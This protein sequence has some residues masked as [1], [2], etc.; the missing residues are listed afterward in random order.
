MA[1]DLTRYKD[2]EAGKLTSENVNDLEASMKMLV[3]RI[4]DH[5]LFPNELARKGFCGHSGAVGHKSTTPYQSDVYVAKLKEIR[6][7]ACIPDEIVLL[8]DA[9]LLEFDKAHNES[10]SYSI[11]SM[12]RKTTISTFRVQLALPYSCHESVLKVHVEVYNGLW[13]IPL[14]ELD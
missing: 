11:V 6:N 13:V 14:V 7:G 3:A 10:I 1:L 9:K 5:F 12:E 8:A 2:S 4:L